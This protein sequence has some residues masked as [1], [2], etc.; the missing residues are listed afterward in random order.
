MSRLSFLHRIAAGSLV[1]A[2][3]AVASAQQTRPATTAPSA[4][5]QTRLT[6][7]GSRGVRVHDPSTIIKCKDEYWVYYTGRGIPSWH[8]KDLVH[9]IAGPAV[10]R[11][12][13]Q[14]VAQAVPANRGGLNFWAPD[15]MKLGDRYLLYYAVSTFG[16]NTSAIGLASNPTLDPADPNYQWTDQGIIIQ[17][18]ATDAFNAIDPAIIKDAD[19]HLWLGFG[20]F[21]SGIQMIPLD[22]QTGKRAATDSRIYPIAKNRQ[23]EASY[24]YYHDGYY[25]CFVNFGLCC[26]GINSTYNVRV[27]RGKTITGPY[28]DKD[29]KNLLNG[30]GTLFLQTD[31]PMIGPGQGAIL[32]D[33]DKFWFSFH[34][35]DATRRGNSEL[36]IRPL[37]W[38]ADGWPVLGTVD[39]LIAPDH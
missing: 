14:W 1:I 10:F 19:G 22:S 31:G 27:G 26:R 32:A 20:S 23:I 39:A 38:A 37:T 13:P 29:G 16:Q 2:L 12:S 7:L 4:D 24:F 9:W 3:L 28:L 33:A 6:Q 21:F 17:S 18:V 25:Y 15:V 35:Y 36:A 5:D 30:G 34:F 11:A 8:S